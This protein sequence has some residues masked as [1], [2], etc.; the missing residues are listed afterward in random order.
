MGGAWRSRPNSPIPLK[1][2]ASTAATA[3]TWSICL[4]E[5]GKKVADQLIPEQVK[6]LFDRVFLGLGLSAARLWTFSEQLYNK[7]LNT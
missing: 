1:I 2:A 6:V 5:Q 7:L 4:P 3:L